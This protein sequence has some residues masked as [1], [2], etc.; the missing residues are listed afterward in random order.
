MSPCSKRGVVGSSCALF[1]KKRLHENSADATRRFKFFI[2]G[3]P[4]SLPTVRGSLP[5]LELLS[6]SLVCI[7]L[8]A[9]RWTAGSY[10]RSI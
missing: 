8:S 2:Q 7:T 1:H 5:W 6:L 10:D 4:R 3:D 9:E